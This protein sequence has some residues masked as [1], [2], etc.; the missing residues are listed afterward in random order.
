M[1]HCKEENKELELWSG[2]KYQVL[3]LKRGSQSKE[4]KRETQG[5]PRMSF[6]L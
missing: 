6:K 5:S 3:K 1:P 2:E 4:L